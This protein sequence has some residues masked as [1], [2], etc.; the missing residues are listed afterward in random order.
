[1][2]FLFESVPRF[3]LEDFLK[4]P[5][6][7]PWINL[8]LSPSVIFNSV[9]RGI[10]RFLEL[11]LKKYLGISEGICPGISP[12]LFS[13]DGSAVSHRISPEVL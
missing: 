6:A 2:E 5:G 10:C 11:F 9:P 8:R 3:I 1:M 13:E 4:L 12:R 7:L